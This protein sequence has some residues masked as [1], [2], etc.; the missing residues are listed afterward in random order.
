MEKFK[1][2]GGSNGL[3]CVRSNI[4]TRPSPSSIF[5]P[6]VCFP[7]TFV[8][9]AFECRIGCYFPYIRH[10][11]IF[12]NF[13]SESCKNTT[14]CMP[15]KDRRLSVEDT[16]QVCPLKI[17]ESNVRFS[18]TKLQVICITPEIELSPVKIS[19]LSVQYLALRMSTRR[20]RRRTR[21][22]NKHASPY[23]S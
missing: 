5:M 14:E 12:H 21:R 18:S 20:R 7:R 8:H 10:R 13:Q 23:G 17:V 2:T 6:Y 4:G 22:W 19:A 3:P 1:N 16:G 15:Y 9:I 11:R